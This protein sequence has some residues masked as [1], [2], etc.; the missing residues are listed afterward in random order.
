MRKIQRVIQSKPLFKNT[1]KKNQ[2]KEIKQNHEFLDMKLS[3]FSKNTT[4][5][6]KWGKKAEVNRSVTICST[7]LL[8]GH[9]FERAPS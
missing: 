4:F 7:Y 3:K 5:I 9:K 6:L 1:R 8:L 2:E